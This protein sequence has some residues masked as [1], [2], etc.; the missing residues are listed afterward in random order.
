MRCTF[1]GMLDFL[2]P[3]HHA[4]F[5]R[6]VDGKICPLCFCVNSG[7]HHSL[8]LHVQL[9]DLHFGFCAISHVHF[10]HDKIPLSLDLS[11]YPV[12]HDLRLC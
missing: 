8:A 10:C 7:G 3:S 12:F 11:R 5:K 1:N 6:E 4:F 2:G 9:R